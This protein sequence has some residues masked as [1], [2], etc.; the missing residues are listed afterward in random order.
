MFCSVGT[1][2]YWRH[3]WTKWEKEKHWVT[4]EE[5]GEEQR[6]VGTRVE[7]IRFCTRCNKTQTTMETFL[8]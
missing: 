7:Q 6:T 4:A 3:L 8:L 1:Q 2:L 5:D